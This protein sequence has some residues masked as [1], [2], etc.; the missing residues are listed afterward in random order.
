MI[1]ESFPV[2]PLGANCTILGDETTHE[3]L[4]IDPGAESE[5]IY[6]RVQALG[7]E[8]KQILLTHGHLDHA[9]GVARLKELTG[10]P[11][12]IHEGD[13]PQLEHMAEQASWLGMA[14][15]KTIVPDDYLTDGKVVGLKSIPAT[16]LHT[17][18]HTQGCVC[19]YLK[20]H[21]LVIAGD[22][23]FAGSIGRT[24]LPGGNSRQIIDSIKT[25]LLALPDETRVITGHGPETTIGEERQ[26]NPFL[27][28]SVPWI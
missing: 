25:R 8:T 24:D 15:P 11:V 20:S 26:S 7:L 28:G 23:L 17:P 21:G 14:A 5:R 13:L 19:L 16:V 3:A 9:G 2:G 6:R 12:F 27:Q 22:T 4:V 18:G 1:V 10:A